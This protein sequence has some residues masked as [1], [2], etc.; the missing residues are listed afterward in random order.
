MW[1]CNLYC[2]KTEVICS[3]GQHAHVCPAGNFH[4]S[5]GHCISMELRCDGINDCG[6]NSDEAGCLKPPCVFGACPHTCTEYK[7]TYKCVCAE[8][9]QYN[10]LNNTC[11]ALGNHLR[12]YWKD[13]VVGL[14]KV[15]ILRVMAI[16]HGN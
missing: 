7:K 16:S 14:L 12:T 11:V 4:C 3:I 13:C 8:G 15:L 1:K 2:F 10:R 5:R 9:Y 6:D